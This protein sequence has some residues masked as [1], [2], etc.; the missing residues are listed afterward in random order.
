SGG[1]W[2]ATAPLIDE[3]LASLPF[4]LAL[5]LNGG[6]LLLT[7][8]IVLALGAPANG[9][10]RAL[11]NLATSNWKS[12]EQRLRGGR[13]LGLLE[14]WLI[15]GLALLGEPT[16]AALVISAKSILRFPELSYSAR[17]IVGTSGGAEG[18]ART[19]DTMTEYF[20]I[21]SLSSWTLALAASL[22][23]LSP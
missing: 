23:L 16:A 19:V 21:G 13:I 18:E 3:W 7:L 14:R 17:G 12:S 20:L 6:S 4:P 5:H 15:F 11:L 22:P 8:G 9:S 10:I 2:Q 1:F